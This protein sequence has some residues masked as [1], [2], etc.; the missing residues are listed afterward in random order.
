MKKWSSKILLAI[1]MCIFFAVPA[2]AAQQGSLLLTKVE[3][4][5]MLF[6]VADEQGIPTEDFAGTVE[7]LTQSDLTPAMAQT[8][9]QHV[10]NKEL[11]GE[12]GVPDDNQEIT[13][14]SLK[15]G[16]YLV[17][18]RGEKA[19]FAPFLLC[20]P[21]TIGG[22]T[23][24]NVLAEPKVNDPTD[25]TQPADPVSPKPNIPQTGAILWPKY[26]LLALGVAAI[27]AGLIEVTRG[28]EK[29]HE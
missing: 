28:R 14:T 7:K 24:Y 11:S 6:F 27:G 3:K 4:P 23:V 2:S 15:T 17:C 19:E 5:A 26:L 25:P 21:I 8:F 13:F 10:Q 29:R 20:I 22:K 18:S 9:Y 16:W 1:A 12:T